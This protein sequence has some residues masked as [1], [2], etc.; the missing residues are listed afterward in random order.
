MTQIH[1]ESHDPTVSVGAAALQRC[2]TIDE[3]A[4]ALS[5][6][7][8][9]VARWRS[10]RKIPGKDARLLLLRV[11]GIAPSAWDAPAAQQAPATPR[12]PSG[13]VKSPVLSLYHEVQRMLTEL[14]DEPD[15]AARIGKLETIAR[16]LSDLAQLTGARHPT[17]RQILATPDWLRIEAAL[18]EATSRNPQCHDAIRAA[19]AELR[20]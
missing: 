15:E 14:P 20:A 12:A 9:S 18:L 17:A 1:A 2:G 13:P 19:L 8:R 10:G 16:I 3:I 11:F 6:S 4:A 7:T 5:T